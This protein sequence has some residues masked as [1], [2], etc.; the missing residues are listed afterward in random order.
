MPAYPTPQ[1]THAVKSA[2]G[3]LPAAHIVHVP[4][5]PA[6]VGPHGWHAVCSAFGSVPSAHTAHVPSL[7]ADPPPHATHVVLSAFGSLPG[8]RREAENVAR[9][10]RQRDGLRVEARLID[11]QP[12]HGGLHEDDDG[13]RVERD[14]ALVE[15]SD[16]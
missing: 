2:F 12:G 11:L 7:P 16:Q 10:L 9:R 1:S 8:A 4:A 3:S 15:R 6:S 13:V 14:G 5:V